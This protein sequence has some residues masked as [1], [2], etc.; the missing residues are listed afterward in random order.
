[1]PM[2][3]QR[4]PSNTLGGIVSGRHPACCT[5]ASIVAPGIQQGRVVFLMRYYRAARA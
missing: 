1:M 4:G 2:N 3:F 5:A